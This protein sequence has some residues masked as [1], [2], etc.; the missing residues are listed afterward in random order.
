MEKDYFIKLMNFLRKDYHEGICYPDPDDLFRAFD[1]FEIP[2]TRVVV[3]GQDPYHSGVATGLAF[4][5]KKGEKTP[6]SLRTILEEIKLDIGYLVKD[7]TLESWAK[8]GVLLINTAL[9]VREHAP[10]SHK[11]IGWE[12]FVSAMLKPVKEVSNV[13]W[14]VWGKKALAFYEKMNVD[15]KKQKALYASHPSP[16]SMNGFFG[17]NHFSKTNYYLKESGRGEIDWINEVL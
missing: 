13:M 16:F 3:I 9:S 11:G 10:D 14:L 12:E 1:F 17:Q 4:G 2:E 7:V 8:Q 5:G 15:K 6:A